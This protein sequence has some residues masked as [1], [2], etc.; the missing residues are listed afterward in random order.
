MADAFDIIYQF[1]IATKELGRV[2]SHQEEKLERLRAEMA[3]SEGAI[4]E[5]EARARDA[6]RKAVEVFAANRWPRAVKVTAETL[7]IVGF[8]EERELVLSVVEPTFACYLKLPP[9]FEVESIVPEFDPAEVQALAS[10]DAGI[11]EPVSI[12]DNDVLAIDTYNDLVDS[13]KE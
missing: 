8:D 7:V 12:P 3:A 4:V 10:L 2:R 13:L 11:I 6:E 1:V 5:A 9:T